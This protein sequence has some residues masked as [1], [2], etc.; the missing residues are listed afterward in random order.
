MNA[1]ADAAEGR[2][3]S[4]RPA[5]SA[6][7]TFTLFAAAC[8]AHNLAIAAH[9]FGHAL[10]TWLGGGE[11]IEFVV[12]PLTTSHVFAGPTFAKDYGYV[13]HTWGGVAFGTAIGVLC[14]IAA[15]WF[16]RG[17]LCWI[18]LHLTGAISLLINGMYL[19]LGSVRPFG[20]AWALVH[21]LNT[22]RLLLFLVGLPIV[23]A[24][25]CVFPVSLRGIGLRRDDSFGKWFLITEI[26]LTGYAIFF[27]IGQMLWRGEG[28]SSSASEFALL[29][30]ATTILVLPVAAFSYWI[31][32]RRSDTSEPPTAEPTWLRAA[33]IFALA[34][35]LL[36]LE[37]VIVSQV[38]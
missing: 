30:G 1:V 29:I 26:G 6:V 22:P 37:L 13:L 16:R 12:N 28:Y 36:V 9:E 17:T 38:H 21:E 25:M 24:F 31:A 4:A 8:L 7:I 23:V 34:L 14:L 18:V 27:A 2:S 32:R 19:T 35:G 3:Q 20:D 5:N 33:T 10:G 11:V 15:S